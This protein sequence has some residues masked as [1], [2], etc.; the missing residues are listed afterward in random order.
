M[1]NSGII[2]IVLFVVLVISTIS[3]SA[4]KIEPKKGS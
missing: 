4:Q 3:V 2:N 1:K